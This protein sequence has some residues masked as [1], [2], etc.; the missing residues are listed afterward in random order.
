[1]T[2]AWRETGRMTVV[3]REKGSRLAAEMVLTGP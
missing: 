2:V 3:E 1:M